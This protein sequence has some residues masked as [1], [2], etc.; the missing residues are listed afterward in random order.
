VRCNCSLCQRRAA[1]LSSRYIPARGFTPVAGLA[2][3]VEPR[4]RFARFEDYF[5]CLLIQS[6]AVAKVPAMLSW[7][8][9]ENRT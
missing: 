1:V 7:P 5:E 6:A 2:G 4:G 8:S 9:P 3:V